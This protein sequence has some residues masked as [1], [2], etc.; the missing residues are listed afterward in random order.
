MKSEDILSHIENA[1]DDLLRMA[2]REKPIKGILVSGVSEQDM[3][4]EDRQYRWILLTKPSWKIVSR[5]LEVDCGM[6]NPLGSI[7]VYFDEGMAMRVIT[8]AEIYQ[9]T[10]GFDMLLGMFVGENSHG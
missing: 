7:P 3:T 5:M 1:R 6:S 10:T 4:V 2:G 8:E 9:G